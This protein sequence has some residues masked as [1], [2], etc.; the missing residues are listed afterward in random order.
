MSTSRGTVDECR[1]GEPEAEGTGGDLEKESGS[2]GAN[3][4]DVFAV[5]V[6]M[7]PK[8]SGEPGAPLC[9]CDAAKPWK[10]AL[11]AVQGELTARQC[12]VNS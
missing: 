7:P 3:S 2:A 4:E 10:A 6:A 9:P 12:C 1:A 5:T 11:D 8:D